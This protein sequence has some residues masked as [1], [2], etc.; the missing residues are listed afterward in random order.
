MEPADGL[1]QAVALD[2]RHGVKGPAVRVP[3]QLVDWHD[4]R[5]FQ[6][7]G[8]LGFQYEVATGGGVVSELRSNFLQGHLTAQ[9][10]VSA[11]KTSLAPP[12]ASDR[13]RR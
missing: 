5:M 1:S 6:T 7:A 11:R 13:R 9:G 2:E 10:G 8:D 12:L 3:T 4:A